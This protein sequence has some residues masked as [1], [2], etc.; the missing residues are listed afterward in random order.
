VEFFLEYSLDELACL[1]SDGD[2][3]LDGDITMTDYFMILGVIIQQNDE[4]SDQTCMDMDQDGKVDVIDI[5]MSLDLI[6]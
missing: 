1:E 5:L 3:N 4:L 2:F 6:F